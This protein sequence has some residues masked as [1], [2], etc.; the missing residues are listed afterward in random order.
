MPTE[1]ELEKTGFSHL[2]ELEEAVVALGKDYVEI[3]KQLAILEA[4]ERQKE[5]E[6]MDR[7]LSEDRKKMEAQI[8]KEKAGTKMPKNGKRT[9][10]IFG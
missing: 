1:E 3:R 10:K 8:K 2:M 9:F 4:K 5:Y 7:D 6:R